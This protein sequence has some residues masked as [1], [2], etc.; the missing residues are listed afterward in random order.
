MPQQRKITFGRRRNN[1]FNHLFKIESPRKEKK[2]RKISFGTRRNN[3]FNHGFLH[4]F[5]IYSMAQKKK[6]KKKKT[7]FFKIGL[8]EFS[9][10]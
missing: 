4:L 1:E 3:R 8:K 5:K 2:K 6:K 9:L 10:T 7:V